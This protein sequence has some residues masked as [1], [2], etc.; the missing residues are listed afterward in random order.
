MTRW[1]DF[2]LDGADMPVIGV[3]EE[4]VRGIT[5]PTCIIPGGD[6]IHPRQ[7]AEDLARI[8]PN[9]EFHD[10]PPQERPEDGGARRKARLQHQRRLSDT[11]IAFLKKHEM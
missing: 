3:P 6:M 8:L 2:F 1:R 5:L 9:A 4:T 11:F 10:L 7:V